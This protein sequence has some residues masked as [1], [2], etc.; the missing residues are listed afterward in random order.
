MMKNIYLLSFLFCIQQVLAAPVTVVGQSYQFMVPEGVSFESKKEHEFYTFR[1][2]EA[3]KTQLLMIHPH[4]APSSAKMLK[5]MADMMAISFEENLPAKESMKLVS[6]K[7]E[8]IQLGL[9]SG[10]QLSFKIEGPNGIHVDQYI[11]LLHDGERVWNAQL[12]GMDEDG[13][14]RAKAI[15]SSAEPITSL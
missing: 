14:K 1:W 10:E 3:A 5:P 8:A 9:F 4:P 12:S 2:G 13:L 6:S 7:R 15:L 11:F